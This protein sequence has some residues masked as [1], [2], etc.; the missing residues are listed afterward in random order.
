MRIASYAALFCAFLL[1]CAGVKLSFS[2]L[3]LLLPCGISSISRANP[4]STEL[5]GNIDSCCEG[6]EAEV[7]GNG[8]R[9]V[10]PPNDPSNWP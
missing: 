1:D 7:V 4:L 10:V 8:V 5:L 9:P 2:S 3:L 6:G